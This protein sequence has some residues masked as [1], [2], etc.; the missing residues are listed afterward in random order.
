MFVCTRFL[1]IPFSGSPDGQA[2]PVQ[3][4][5]ISCTL[6]KEPTVA[7]RAHCCDGYHEEAYQ[8]PLSLSLLLTMS[9]MKSGGT[10]HAS[11]PQPGLLKI[12]SKLE[13]NK[14]NISNFNNIN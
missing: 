13:K 9:D 5:S 7:N 3:H 2:R 10:S 4:A 8:T 6:R 14:G 12:K 11:A 1:Q